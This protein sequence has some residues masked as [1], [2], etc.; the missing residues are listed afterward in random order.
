[1]TGTYL[2]LSNRFQSLLI[3]L[4]IGHVQSDWL[5]GFKILVE[6]KSDIALLFV[7]RTTRTHLIYL[8]IIYIY[9]CKLL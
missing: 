7:D 9:I 4:T 8:T 2:Y 6:V 1:M 5:L 3:E